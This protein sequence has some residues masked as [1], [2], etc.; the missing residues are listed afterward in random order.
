[1]YAAALAKG[2]H[3]SMYTGAQSPSQ[4]VTAFLQDLSDTDVE[5]IP[6]VR[7]SVTVFDLFVCTP[8]HVHV[9][10][11]KSYTG[12]SVQAPAQVAAAKAWF[13]P[14]FVANGASA[15][16]SCPDWH[17]NALIGGCTDCQKIYDGS[18]DREREWT[19]PFRETVLSEAAR[20]EAYEASVSAL[21][22]LGPETTQ[23]DAE[24]SELVAACEEE[25]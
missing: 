25:E 12:A 4:R 9:P 16:P 2:L 23:D 13:T 3:F 17:W 14:D 11:L 24:L 10:D 7:P 22:R 20:R 1:M 21:F 15:R 6:H 5:F 19:P 8:M 18:T